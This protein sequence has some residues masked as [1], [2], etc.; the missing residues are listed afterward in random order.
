[1]KINTKF[2]GELEVNENDL[3]NFE[4]GLPGFKEYTSFLFISDEAND[5]DNNDDKPNKKS[6]FSWLQSVDDKDVAFVLFDVFAFIPDYSPIINIE[7]LSM[8]GTNTLDDVKICCIANIPSD[9]KKMS[10]NLK[11]PIVINTKNNKAKQIICDNDN[12]SLKHYIYQ[13]E[14]SKELEEKP[15]EEPQ[16]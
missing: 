4:D 9:I 13:E 5:K 11:A 15:K 7:F 10:I 6:P 3:I 2:F 16:E 12:Y 14:A 1:M 8:L